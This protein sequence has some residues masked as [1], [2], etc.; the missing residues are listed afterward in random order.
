MGRWQTPP[1]L[2][3]PLNVEVVDGEIILDGQLPVS[4][5][6]TSD[7]AIETGV[8]LVNAGLTNKGQ[9]APLAEAERKPR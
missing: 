7:A 8:R 9:A 1:L 2:D 4:V 6:L 5:A 3:E